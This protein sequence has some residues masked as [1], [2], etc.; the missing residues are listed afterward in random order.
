MSRIEELL[1]AIINGDEANIK[2]RS[3]AEEYLVACACKECDNLP[4]PKSRLDALYYKLAQTISEG[5]GGGDIDFTLATAKAADVAEGKTFYAG[6]GTLKTGSLTLPD[7]SATTATATDVA[8]GKKF[9]NA[10]GELVDGAMTATIQKMIELN[11][12]IE[13]LFTALSIKEATPLLKGIDTSNYRLFTQM[14]YNCMSLVTAPYFD[15]SNGTSF[16]DLF[17]GCRNL[18]NIPTY[19]FKNANNFMG[20]FQECQSIEETPPINIEHPTT[21]ASLFRDCKLLKTVHLFNTETATSMGTMF[22]GCVVLET[23]PAFNCKSVTSF[24]NFIMGC[25]NI[26][27]IWIK[28]IKADL[29]VASGTSYGNL[30]TQ[31]SLISLIKEL[32]DNSATTTTKRLTMGSTNLAKLATVYVKPYT[33]TEAQLAED[34]ELPNKLPYEVCESTDEGAILITEYATLKKWTLA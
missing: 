21:V 16:Q 7:L 4:T 14:F 28:N 18:K 15:T 23:I 17:R 27:E 3:R 11:G 22:Y 25:T 33:P 31:E 1:Q 8:S 12:G 9:Y 34:P 29:Q 32:W 10:D 20:V 19:D 26:K 6:N 5:G 13:K 24:S 30:L 2:P